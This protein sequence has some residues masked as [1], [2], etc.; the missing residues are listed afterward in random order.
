[1]IDEKFEEK[2]V[3]LRKPEGFDNRGVVLCDVLF[4]VVA[5]AL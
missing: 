4:Y 3:D 2:S 1:M 5:T